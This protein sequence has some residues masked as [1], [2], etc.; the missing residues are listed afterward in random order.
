MAMKVQGGRFV[1]SGR[2]N[3]Q[4]LANTRATLRPLA[5]A[6]WNAIKAFEDK[7]S[8]LRVLGASQGPELMRM[9]NRIQQISKEITG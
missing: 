8:A 3:A 5:D 9:R 6:A 4:E 1:E 2:T 7:A